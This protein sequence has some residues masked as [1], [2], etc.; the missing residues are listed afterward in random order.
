MIQIGA[1]N[2]LKIARRTDHGMYLTDGQDE[3]LLPRKFIPEG[4]GEG[5]QLRV[6][7]T[8][9]SED[10][11]IATTQRP[12]AV[13]GEFAT[14]Q[15]KMVGAHGAFMDWGLDKDLLVPFAEQFRAIEEGAWYVVRVELDTKTNRVFGSTRLGKYLKGDVRNLSEG[16][17]VSLLVTDVVPEGARVVVD[18]AYFGMVFPDELHERL[19][20]GESR[21]GYIKRIREDGGIALT[22]SPMGYQGAVDESPRI[23]ERLR[24]EG[25]FMAIGDKSPPEDIR[26]EFGLSKATFK[27]AL[28]HLMKSGRIEQ[29]FHGIRLKENGNGKP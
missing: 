26:R 25:G 6:F 13:V 1:Y 19:R 18:S 9:D 5:E 2:R 10:R 28:G 17:E 14:M 11:P 20:I 27:K 16:Q 7:V 3:V 8:T 4:I 23:V 15:A 29:T 22:L 24:R 21:R 12:K